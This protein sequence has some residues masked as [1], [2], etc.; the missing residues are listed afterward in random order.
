MSTRTLIA[1]LGGAGA[2]GRITVRDLV[3]TAPTGVD[4][5][6][7]DYNLKAAKALAAECKGR[8]RAV[9]VDV[10]KTA[11]TAKALRGAF[12]FINCCQHQFNLPVMKAALAA[13][14]HYT[15]LGGLFH[16]TRQQLKL[17]G[18]FKKKKLLALLGMGAAPGLVNV[19]ARAAAD[20]MERVHEIHIAVGNIDRTPG[21]ETG[22]LGS[23]YSIDTILDEASQPAALFTDGKFTFVPAM[24]GTDPVLFPTPVG[25][26]RPARTI[27]SEV[28]TLPLTYKNKG[29]QEVSFRIAF[30]DDLDRKLRFLHALG[31]IDTKPVQ[32][33]KV[34]VVPRDLL[35]AL[36]KRLPAPNPGG[37]PDE[38]EVLRVTVRGVRA[39]Q[40]VE[41]ILD[42]HTPGIRDWEKGVDV[43]TG[44][45]PSIAMQML[46]RGD[47]TARGAVAPEVAV[48]PEPFFRELE[49]RQM[50]VT[51]ASQVT[52]AVA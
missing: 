18:Q 46:L 9:Q 48:P 24:S 16:F 43:N 12:A 5:V 4:I 26:R 13:G 30:S 36:V 49:R 52:E 11:A 7:A 22:V 3:E 40:S 38:Y 19:M 21:R 14:A 37:I 32:V 42:C 17:G 31:M 10:T 34:K 39:G 28:A 8:A 45:P 25:T 51:R 50:T 44:C 23:S 27:H 33:G 41:D 15:D 6:I 35:A 29:V 1:V 20:T 47:I 2:M